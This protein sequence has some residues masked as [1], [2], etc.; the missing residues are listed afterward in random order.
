MLPIYLR[1]KIGQRACIS[2]EKY[3]NKHFTLIAAMTKNRIIAP[4]V[5][6]DAVNSATFEAYVKHFLIEELKPGQVLIMDNLSSH[7]SQKVKKILKKK[8]IEIVFLPPYSPDLNPIEMAWSKLKTY[9]RKRKAKSEE[10][11][12]KAIRAGLNKIKPTEC[13]N[14]INKMSYVGL[15]HN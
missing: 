11:L 4:M 2:R 3:K 9:L 7:K 15:C 12:H 14:W 1:S 10:A 6:E 13:K 8:G 5:V